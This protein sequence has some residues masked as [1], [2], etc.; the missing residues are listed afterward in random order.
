MHL[1]PD[2]HSHGGP[3]TVI[4]QTTG[5]NGQDFALGLLAALHNAVG[6]VQASLSGFGGGFLPDDNTVL[7]WF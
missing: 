5:A 1:I 6:Q 7:K 4:E 3:K 2:T